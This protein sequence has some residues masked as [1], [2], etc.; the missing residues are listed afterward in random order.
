M[1]TAV[2]ITK[3]LLTKPF[4]LLICIKF[5]EQPPLYGAYLYDAVYQYAVGLNRTLA[6]GYTKKNGT[7]IINNLLN[8]QYSS[9]LVDGIG[10]QYKHHFA[11]VETLKEVT[12]CV[13]DLKYIYSQ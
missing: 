5:V 8:R 10:L 13:Q 9:K 6:Q 1:Q 4:S 7:A 2:C 11:V 12:N 3:V